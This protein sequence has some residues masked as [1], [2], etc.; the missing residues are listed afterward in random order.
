M[1]VD[2]QL[3]LHDLFHATGAELDGNAYAEAVDAEFALKIDTGRED[4]LL[5]QQ[6]PE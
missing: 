1:F 3:D 4:A 5:V 2:G 6:D